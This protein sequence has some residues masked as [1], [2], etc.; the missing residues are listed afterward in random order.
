MVD[1][2]AGSQFLDKLASLPP[3]SQASAAAPAPVE[4]APTGS[5]A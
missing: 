2:R 5:G 1:P 3:S 4:T